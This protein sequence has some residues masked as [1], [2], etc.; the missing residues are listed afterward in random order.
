MMMLHC[1]LTK[2]CL[3]LLDGSSQILETEKIIMELIPNFIEISKIDSR[4]LIASAP[5]DSVDF[6]SRCFFPQ[7]GVNEDPV[8]GSA[9]TTMIPYWSKILSK[10]ILLAH[11]LSKRGGVLHCENNDER[12][13]I[14]GDSLI[15]FIGEI[16]L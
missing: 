7:T 1:Y 11:Q 16:S 5:G 2:T 4:G 9:H 10:D 8:T 15:Y 13:K 3:H 6:V 12:V 14:G